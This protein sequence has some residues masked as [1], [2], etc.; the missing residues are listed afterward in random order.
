MTKYFCNHCFKLVVSVKNGHKPCPFC[1]AYA[2]DLLP[3]KK[4]K[5]EVPP[6]SKHGDHIE[7]YE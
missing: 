1:G 2:G 5:I 4:C 7:L 6:G 3:I